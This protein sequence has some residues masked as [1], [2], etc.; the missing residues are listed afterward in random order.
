MFVEALVQTLFL[1]WTS[2]DITLRVHHSVTSRYIS[3]LKKKIA[4]LKF[5]KEMLFFKDSNNIPFYKKLSA[6]FIFDPISRFS[7]ITER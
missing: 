2:T 6:F 3:K 7:S 1:T 4:S 5:R